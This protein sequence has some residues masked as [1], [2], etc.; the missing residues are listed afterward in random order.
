MTTIPPTQWIIDKGWP[1]PTMADD[2]IQTAKR[3]RW[4]TAFPFTVV[5]DADGTVLARKS[6]QST[7][8]ETVAF[9]DAALAGAAG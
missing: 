3:V 4:R 1:W 7:G 8:D 6:G 9:L 5:L 2:E